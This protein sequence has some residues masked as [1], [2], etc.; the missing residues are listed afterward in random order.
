[1]EQRWGL[2][3]TETFFPLVLT[4]VAIDAILSNSDWPAFIQEYS[5]RGLTIPSG[6][7]PALSS[8]TGYFTRHTR[9]PYFAMRSAN[10]FRLVM[11]EKLH[12]NTT[13]V[14]ASTVLVI[15]AGEQEIR[16][17]DKERI[18]LTRKI[19]ERRSATSSLHA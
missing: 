8:I 11:L 15:H 16:F 7:F 5:S 3:D 14:L 9:E 4:L 17:T 19:D 6:K 18:K 1:M 12:G 10:D 13:P 2:V